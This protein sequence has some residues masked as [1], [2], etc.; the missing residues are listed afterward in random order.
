MIDQILPSAMV[1]SFRYDDTGPVD[2]FPEETAYIARA[3]DKRRREFGTVRTCAREALAEL[4][5]PPLPIMP[6]QRGAP[7]WPDGVIGSMTHCDGYRAAAV[8]LSSQAAGVGIDAEP[9][10]PLPS[11]VLEAIALPAERRRL[12]VL[13]VRHPQVP[14]DRMLF[15]AKESVFKV[16]YPIVGTELG[17]EEAHITLMPES[18]TFTARLL[19]GSPLVAS[20]GLDLLAGR[21]ICRQGLVVT[22]IALASK[23]TCFTE[24]VSDRTLVGPLVGDLTPI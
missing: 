1:T 5:F 2:L 22:A 6:G 21:W 19:V 17:F 10:A 23:T 12:E 13:A 20:R 16:W 11:G 9:A 24:W 4:G 14:W 18:G 15:S 7:S 3:V 8:A